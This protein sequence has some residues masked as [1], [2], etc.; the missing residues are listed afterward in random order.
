MFYLLLCDGLVLVFGLLLRWV[1]VLC[2][3]LWFCCVLFGLVG[4]GVFVCCFSG[5]LGGVCGLLCL[6]L[7]V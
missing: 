1:V 2:C 6:R 3:L 5:Y 4:V 7:I